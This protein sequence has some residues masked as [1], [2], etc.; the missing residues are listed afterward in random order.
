M[1]RYIIVILMAVALLVAMVTPC[2]AHGALAG[3]EDDNN[4]TTAFNGVS[5]AFSYYNGDGRLVRYSCSP[6]YQLTPSP[7][8][9]DY[10]SD[11]LSL[12][13]Y[14]SSADGVNTSV[15]YVPSTYFVNGSAP[16]DNDTIAFDVHFPAYTLSFGYAD[17]F[18]DTSALPVFEHSLPVLTNPVTTEVHA[19]YFN[20][21][22]IALGDYTIGNVASSFSP[23]A[24]VRDNAP[25]GADYAIVDEFVISGTFTSDFGSA[26]FVLRVPY[27]S[28]DVP[29]EPF[30]AVSALTGVDDV[31]IAQRIDSVDVGTFL[32][33]SVSNFLNFEIADGLSLYVILIT[34]VTIPILVWILKLFAGG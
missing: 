13:G 34:I 8:T 2:F 31:I 28:N 26:P 20:S 7:A 5:V 32:W 23:Y 10:S 14:S 27:W 15:R 9:G 4:L 6:A 1:K 18:Y 3:D 33:D 16:T 22:G 12:A 24:V 17:S 11:A 19:T 29:F 21:A 30:T 25:D